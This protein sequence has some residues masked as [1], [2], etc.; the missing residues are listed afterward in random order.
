MFLHKENHKVYRISYA[1]P[2]I[3]CKIFYDLCSAA[4]EKG[5]SHSKCAGWQKL[6]TDKL[7]WFI[8]DYITDKL[9]FHTNLT[10]EQMEEYM[11]E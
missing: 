4:G 11:E 5:Q 1:I 3:K 10:T 7:C 8:T 9:W 2:C 6:Y